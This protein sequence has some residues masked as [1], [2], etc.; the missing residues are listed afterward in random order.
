MLIEDDRGLGVFEMPH[1]DLDIL[2]FSIF[3]A[4]L[5]LLEMPYIDLDISHLSSTRAPLSRVMEGVLKGDRRSSSMIKYDRGWSMVIEGDQ[6]LSKSFWRMI[7][8]VL[9]DDQSGSRG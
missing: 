4:P 6:V 8:V 3:R 5:G 7:K 1:I 9:K 2:H